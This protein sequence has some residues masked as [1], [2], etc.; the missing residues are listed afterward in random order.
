[1]GRFTDV[2]RANEEEGIQKTIWWGVTQWEKEKERSRRCEGC[3]GN[4]CQGNICIFRDVIMPGPDHHTYAGEGKVGVFAVLWC[5][6]HTTSSVYPAGPIRANPSSEEPNRFLLLQC[7]AICRSLH[8]SQLLRSQKYWFSMLCCCTFHPTVWWQ[9]NIIAIN[10]GRFLTAMNRSGY[11]LTSC[12]SADS[13]HHGCLWLLSC[14]HHGQ[15]MEHSR[16]SNEKWKLRK[17]L[18]FAF[19]WAAS[20]LK[21]S[22]GFIDDNWFVTNAVIDYIL[23]CKL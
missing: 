23:L 7:E 20:L 15:H 13:C 3:M 5:V 2:R 11:R 10:R 22:S 12:G 18:L 9:L 21:I 4:K 19:H 16:L 6:R 14:L 1:M 8:E 17:K